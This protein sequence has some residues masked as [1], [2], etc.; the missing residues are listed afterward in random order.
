MH[1]N[2]LRGDLVRL[3]AG[4]WLARRGASI[5]SLSLDVNGVAGR[6]DEAVC[7]A[8]TAARIFP[9]VVAR[10][11]G[12]GRSVWSASRSSDPGFDRL[13]RDAVFWAAKREQ[14]AARLEVVRGD[15]VFL[16]AY[17]SAR[18]AAVRMRAMP[19]PV[20]TIRARLASRRV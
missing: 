20:S 12:A 1:P 17:P 18:L 11:Y 4:Q 3:A 7:A 9:A 14:D 16:H 5:S 8:R 2:L 10:D 15:K 19:R 13:L 6:G